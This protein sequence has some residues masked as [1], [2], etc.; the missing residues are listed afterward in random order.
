[1]SWESIEAY[2]HAITCTC[3]LFRDPRR[4]GKFKVEPVL[5]PLP[6][7]AAPTYEESTGE[8]SRGEQLMHT[9]FEANQ[10]TAGSSRDSTFRYSSCT[11]NKRAVCVRVATSCFCCPVVIVSCFLRST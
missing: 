7:K 10:V 9:G 11:G 8:N 6:D 1:M 5:R 4:E 2:V 3:C